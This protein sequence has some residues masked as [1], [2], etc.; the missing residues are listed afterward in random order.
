MAPLQPAG[1]SA[2]EAESTRVLPFSHAARARSLGLT[3]PPPLPPM[4][5]LTALLFVLPVAL[6]AQGAPPWQQRVEYDMD[7]VMDAPAHQFTGRQRLTLHNNSPDTLRYVY[8]HLY[9]NAFQPTSLMAERNRHLPDPDG[10]V[11]PRIFNLGPDE[12]GYQRVDALTQDGAPVAFKV[13]DTLLRADLARPIPPGGASTFEMQFHAQV[14]LQTRRSGRDSREGIDYSMSQW[15]PKLAQY[16]TRGWHADPYVGREFYAP[17]GSF[18]VRITIPTEYMLGATGVLQNPDEIGHGYGTRDRTHAPGTPITWHFRADDVHDFAWAADRDYVHDR[19]EGADGRQY[20]LLYQPDVAEGWQFLRQYVPAVINYYSRRVGPYPWPQFTVAQA[21][22]GGMEYPMVNFITGGRTPGSLVG[23]VAHEAAH[24]WFYGTL[25]SNES[26]FA[27]M[28]EGFTDYMT[29]EAIAAL[30]TQRPASHRGAML[31]VMALQENGLFEPISG[32]SDHY[33]TNRAYGTASY[34]GGA[35]IADLLGYVMGDSLRDR[36]FQNYFREFRLRHPQPADVERVAE[37]TSGIELDWFFQQI[38][39]E[40]V[41]MDYAITGLT[42]RPQGDGTFETTVHLARRDEM[43]FPLDVRVRLADGSEA[44]ATVPT[45]EMMRAKPVPPGWTTAPL[46]GWTFPTYTLRLTTP[47][48]AVEAEIDPLGRTP[49]Y[50]RLNNGTRF[51]LDVAFFKAPAPTLDQYS[52]GWRPLVTYAEAYGVGVG[53]RAAGA[54]WMDNHERHASVTFWPLPLSSNGKRPGGSY[55][56]PS[57]PRK[58]QSWFEGIDYSVGGEGKWQALSPATRVGGSL[59]KHQGILE[60]TV[61]VQHTLGKWAALG[62]DRGT[63][64]LSL[65]HHYQ[66]Y[67]RSFDPYA[68][69]PRADGSAFVQGV[70]RL[71]GTLRYDVR[72]AD[73]ALGFQLDAGGSIAKCSDSA[74]NGFFSCGYNGIVSA[75]RAQVWLAKGADIGP[76]R[77]RA[78]LYGAF[79]PSTLAYDL[80]FPLG[81]ATPDRQWRNAASRTLIGALGEQYEIGESESRYDPETGLYEIRFSDN[82]KPLFFA[83]SGVGPVGYW[84][85][86]NTGYFSFIN[87]QNRSLSGSLELE[88]PAL[89]RRLPLRLHAFSGAALASATFQGFSFDPQS[90][91]ADAGLGA[92]LD[93]PAIPVLRR[94]TAQSDVLQGLK[95]V[96]KLPFYVYQPDRRQM[97]NDMG[98]TINDSGDEIKFRYLFGVEVGL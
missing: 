95:L 75:T 83:F 44:W 36:F 37:K 30:L 84:T 90:F 97:A 2:A 55:G 66:P 39:R 24:E 43:L 48:R 38:T 60:N 57:G 7:I 76:L 85:S 54:Y 31:G 6:H 63:L 32:N 70:Q 94:W 12:I 79:A 86:F 56:G 34:G 33:A 11:V 59:D 42:S 17:Y 69:D 40:K 18:D 52:V 9:F 81:L 88:T 50:N 98:E 45:S 19:I 23:V 1:C 16:D 68:A 29:G 80:R 82:T 74:G 96:A 13:D 46:W 5:F 71:M 51:P 14:P 87:Y 8:Y 61:Y 22:D 27:W 20:H 93:V 78:K 25:G 91:F 53:V 62:R 67:S 26:D 77:A 15:Y 58:H 35:M 64:R 28:D 73:D 21:G 65:L 89:S 49:D 10:R 41:R 4:R 72:R 92:R 47:A 3:L